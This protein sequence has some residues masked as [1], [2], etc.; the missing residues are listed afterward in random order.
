MSAGLWS[1]KY[2]PKSLDHIKHHPEIVNKLRNYGNM[3]QMPHLLFIGPSGTGK[4]TC[5]LA[6]AHELYRE[7][8][9]NFIREI[10]PNEF[11]YLPSK[12]K[13]GSKSKKDNFEDYLKDLKDFASIAPMD[14]NVSF[15]IIILYDA[16][17]AKERNFQQFL[18]RTMEMYS[19]TCRFY[20]ET[21]MEKGIIDPI[22]SRCDVN[23]FGVINEE[24]VKSI[25]LEIAEKESFLLTEDGLE[26]I[27][28]SSGSNLRNAI[29]R[30][31]AAAS[32]S[33]GIITDEIVYKILGSMFTQKVRKMIDQGLNNNFS[34]ARQILRD[35]LIDEQIDAAD[36]LKKIDIAIMRTTKL[37]QKQKIKLQDY[38]AQVDYNLTQGSR[39]EI[40]LSS[41]IAKLAII[42]ET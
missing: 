22:K 33:D 32:I 9:K 7:N 34:E 40:H 13:K 30:L 42:R 12:R 21:H 10:H 28:K 2:R 25:L 19:G 14:P 36:I 1:E 38:I 11:R 31:Q 18:R 8:Y 5:I 20:L 6:L 4:T 39:P 17:I 16:H 23:H 24:N 29:N 15:K 27:Y 41:L 37:N 3:K 35:L 26:T